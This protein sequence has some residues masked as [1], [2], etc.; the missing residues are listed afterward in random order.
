MKLFSKVLPPP[1][2]WSQSRPA[3]WRDRPP[4]SSCPFSPAEEGTEK[5]KSGLLLPSPVHLPLLLLAPSSPP[6]LRPPLSWPWLL[7]D[8][9]GHRLFLP[10]EA[11]VVAMKNTELCQTIITRF[12][13]LSERRFHGK[14]D[15]LWEVMREIVSSWQ[16]FQN[17]PKVKLF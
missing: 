10:L 3:C 8:F 12:A 9:S 4:A 1:H 13:V 6:L 16:S 17:T 2:T 14:Q 15:S 7:Q 5:W 11:D